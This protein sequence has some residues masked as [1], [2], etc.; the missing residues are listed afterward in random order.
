MVR[1][2]LILRLS[3][4]VGLLAACTKTYQ[5]EA[6]SEVYDS[7][8]LDSL[9]NKVSYITVPIEI[10]ISN[11]ERQINNNFSGLI[12]ADSSFVGDDLKFKIWKKT[13]LSFEHR[14]NGI[15]DFRV[16]LKIWVEKRVKILGMTQTPSTEFEILAK[17]SSKPFIS[18]NW[19]LK[20]VTNAEGFEWISEPKLSIAGFSIPVAGLIGGMIENY[21]SSIARLIDT[22]VANEVDLVTPVLNAWNAIKEPSQLS[23]EYNLWLQI[24]PQDVLM[25]KLVFDKSAIRTSIAIKAFFNSSVGKSNLMVKKS[26]ELPPIKFANQLPHGFGVHLYNLVTF[27]EAEKIAKGMLVGQ[28][29]AFSGDREIE[30]LGV[31]IYGGSNNRLVI[32]IK[33]D[34]DLRGTIFLTGDPVYDKDRR[35]VILKDTKFDVKTKNLVAKAASWL[36]EET[37]VSQIENEFGIP[38]DPIFKEAKN[39][40]NDYLNRN[41]NGLAVQGKITE[42][43]PENVILQSQGLMTVVEAKGD[44][45]IKLTS[46]VPKK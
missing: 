5:P 18:S 43:I 29:F 4:I 16:P 44:L 12:Y 39:S 17:F 28:K 36:L 37:V 38:V 10:D 26:V 32:Q 13:D 19:E 30:V 14:E 23:E 25:T 1:P 8:G 46:F 2:W 21:Q 9:S 11:I 20:T 40:V 6:P 45:A 34:G 35:Q 22:Q 27:S 15:F 24:I 31:R 33:T 41:Y 3:V 7:L 42:I